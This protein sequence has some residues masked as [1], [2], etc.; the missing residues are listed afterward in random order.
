MPMTT[1][2]LNEFL[3]QPL[4]AVLGTVDDEGRPRSAPIW[5]HWEDGAAY[6]F[7]SRGTLKWRNIQHQPHA[8][9]C[10]DWREVPYRSVIM[11]GPVEE[12]D[13]PLYD[14]VLSMA[15]RY[16]GE[17]EGRAFAEGYRGDSPNVVAF[18]LVPRHISSFNSED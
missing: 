5:F 13:R 6:M 7:T 15:I 10:I 16:Y 8:S 17:E 12:V 11:D 2:E 4:V 14:L 3:S 1:N 18:R 9:L